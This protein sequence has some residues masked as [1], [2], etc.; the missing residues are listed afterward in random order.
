MLLSTSAFKFNLRRYS[1]DAGMDGYL[2][3][4]VQRITLLQMMGFWCGHTAVPRRSRVKGL[5]F[6]QTL[7]LK[8]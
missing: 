6:T 5:G 2:A 3:K 7:N 4:P 8:P 1:L